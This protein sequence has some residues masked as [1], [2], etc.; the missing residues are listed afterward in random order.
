MAKYLEAFID[1]AGEIEIYLDRSP[2]DLVPSLSEDVPGAYVLTITH[3]PYG[4]KG[5][6]VERYRVTPFGPS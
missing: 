3:V 6:T 1:Q 5:K 4:D 2:G